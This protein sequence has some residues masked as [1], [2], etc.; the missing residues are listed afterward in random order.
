LEYGILVRKLPGMRPLE[1]M[2]RILKGTVKDLRGTG[3]EIDSWMEL[4]QAYANYIERGK[5]LIIIITF[6]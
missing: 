6:L 3:C 2:M 5:F 4:A 1:R